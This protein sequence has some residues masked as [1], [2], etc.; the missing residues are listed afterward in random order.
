[1]AALNEDDRAMAKR[2]DFLHKFETNF[3]HW[4]VARPCLVERAGLICNCRFQV[5]LN[6]V[7]YYAS[8]E[9]VSL[10]PLVVRLNSVKM[11]T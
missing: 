3:S 1:M 6:C 4:C 11:G 10:L 2:W 5:H 7:Q 9:N 8:S